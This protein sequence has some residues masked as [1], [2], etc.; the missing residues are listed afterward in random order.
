M[1]LSNFFLS[2]I[3]LSWIQKASGS[4]LQEKSDRMI[5][6]IPNADSADGESRLERLVV[7]RGR[8]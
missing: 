4:K 8:V 3:K 5:I 1:K 7:E 2:S 6:I